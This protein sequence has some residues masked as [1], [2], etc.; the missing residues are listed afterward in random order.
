MAGALAG[1]EERMAKGDSE[2]RAHHAFAHLAV[3]IATWKAK[4]TI[5]AREAK[6]YK[7]SIFEKQAQSIVEVQ[8]W[9]EDK[10]KRDKVR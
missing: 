4:L 7:G 8:H 6:V 9:M 3:D 2:I 10:C 5:F 1:S